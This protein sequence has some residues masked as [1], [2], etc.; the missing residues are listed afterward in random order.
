MDGCRAEQMWSR[1]PSGDT[2]LTVSRTL[3]LAGQAACTLPHV[4]AA[5]P[6]PP[7]PPAQVAEA[8]LAA[9]DS[10]ELAAAVAS[11]HDGYKKWVNGVGKAQGRKGK[12]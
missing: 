4:P 2:V 5:L 12:R 1:C 3:S 10:G 11:G 9:Y 8:V 7:L 6:L